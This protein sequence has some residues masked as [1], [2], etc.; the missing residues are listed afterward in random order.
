MILIL[1]LGV[2]RIGRKKRPDGNR[3]PF[4]TV[5]IAAKDESSR[6]SSCLRALESQDYPEELFDVIVV[7]D[8]SEDGTGKIVSGFIGKHPKWKLITIDR[9]PEGWSPKKYALNAGIRACREETGIFA[10]TDA[11]CRPSGEWLTSIAK[12]F[13]HDTGM[14][15]GFSPTL[16]GNREEK[17][18]GWRESL[19]FLSDAALRS[20]SYLES[21]AVGAVAAGTSGIEFPVTAAGRNM[22]LRRTAHT[23]AGA[24]DAIRSFV[25]GDDDLLLEKVRTETKWKVEYLA[26]PSSVVWTFAP[27]SWME[28]F[29]ARLRHS[30]KVLD[31]KPVTISLL[32][33]L[34]FSHVFTAISVV[35]SLVTLTPGPLAVFFLPMKTGIDLLLL[36]IFA[37]GRRIPLL[38]LVYLP[39]VEIFF[40]FYVAL[41]PPVS[42]I[43]GFN[44][45]GKRYDSRLVRTGGTGK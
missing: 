25:S 32:L 20:F 23:D 2:V 34:Y 9:T 36:L 4:I 24:Y 41:V 27:G 44:W 38:P 29:Q 17:P 31:Y 1:I 14:V 11:D 12:A 30:S 35:M 22:A 6:I 39:L 28:M 43:G 37:R 10:F 3:K 26:E 18:H 21:T 7:D 5:V 45:K 8:R 19:R 13:N 15:I 40:L 33:F 16:P 42:L